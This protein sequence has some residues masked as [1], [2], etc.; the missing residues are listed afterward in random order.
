[1]TLSCSHLFFFLALDHL[2]FVW[3]VPHLLKLPPLNEWLLLLS[4]VEARNLP[5]QPLWN[6]EQWNG[7]VWQ[8]VTTEAQRI[9]FGDGDNLFIHGRLCNQKFHSCSDQHCWCKLKSLCL[10]WQPCSCSRCLTVSTPYF[11]PYQTHALATWFISLLWQCG[12]YIL[13]PL[14]LSWKGQHLLSTKEKM[15][16]RR[17]V[18]ELPSVHLSLPLCHGK[19][20][21]HSQWKNQVF[22]WA[23]LRLAEPMMNCSLQLNL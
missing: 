2:V 15:V 9:H 6:P 3:E 23:Q 10:G 19:C 21:P 22:P 20:V 18:N 5:C 12:V 17:M 1:M 11:S 16:S 13:D 7:P 14:S 4:F 8:M